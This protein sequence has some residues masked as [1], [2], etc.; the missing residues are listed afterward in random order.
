[1]EIWWKVVKSWLIGYINF[2]FYIKYIYFKR[3]ETIHSQMMKKKVIQTQKTRKT[4]QIS[5]HLQ[6]YAL[7]KVNEDK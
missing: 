6:F 2:Y 5:F 3:Y 4:M 7:T 1:M